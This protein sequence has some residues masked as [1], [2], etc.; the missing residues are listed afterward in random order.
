MEAQEFVAYVNNVRKAN[1]NKW[2]TYLGDVDGKFVELKGY[3]LWLQI[4]RVDGL[5]YSSGECD[6]VAQDLGR[7]FKI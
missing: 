6:R 3:N 5:A 4:Y 7:P 2:Y 1:K